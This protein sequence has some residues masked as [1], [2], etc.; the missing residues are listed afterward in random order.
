MRGS[1]GFHR[2]KTHSQ[3]GERSR[4][5]SGY[6]QVNIGQTKGNIPEKEFD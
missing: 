3:A 5:S 4:T 6:E 1:E 2:R